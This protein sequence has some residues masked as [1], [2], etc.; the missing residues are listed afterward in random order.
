MDETTI[1]KRAR[2]LISTT[3]NSSGLTHHD[4]D[5]AMESLAKHSARAGETAA[6]AYV[7]LLLDQPD[8]DMTTLA[9]AREMLAPNA[10]SA[11]EALVADAEAELD[12]YIGSVARAGETAGQTMARLEKAR[13]GGFERRYTLLADARRHAL[14]NRR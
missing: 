9:K 7:R 3:D 13:D 8:D 10:P 14:R 4:I 2:A 6:K 11:P 1:I 5:R 12:A